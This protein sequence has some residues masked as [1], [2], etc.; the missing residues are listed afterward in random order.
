MEG[1]HK[2]ADSP[3]TVVK[4]RI[5]S[6]E[7]TAKQRLSVHLRLLVGN[8]I[9]V[10]VMM[11]GFDADRIGES[12][13]TNS[14]KS[15]IVLTM[16]WWLCSEVFDMRRC[17][18]TN[19]GWEIRDF[20]DLQVHRSWRRNFTGS[21]EKISWMTS[22]GRVGSGSID[23]RVSVEVINSVML[24]SDWEDNVP[25][26]WFC[27]HYITPCLFVRMQ[28]RKGVYII[29]M[30]AVFPINTILFFWIVL[31]SNCDQQAK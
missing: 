11:F 30:A 9:W 13:R 3:D 15:L 2:I 25:F 14:C 18:L 31:N 12:H 21:L 7:Q 16:R 24:V 6:Q 17:F 4:Q 28:T 29:S 8:L 27:P 19:L 10:C 22:N 26:L 20:Q 1:F 23:V 5:P